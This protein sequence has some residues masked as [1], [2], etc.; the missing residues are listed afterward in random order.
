MDTLDRWISKADAYVAGYLRTLNVT[1]SKHNV[2]SALCVAELE[3]RCGD[4][5]W[6]NWGG[7]TA[8]QLAPDERAR[9]S[10]AN[11]SPSNPDDLLAA[12]N[13]LGPQPHKVLGQDSDPRAGWYWIWFYLPSTPADGAAYFVKVLVVQRPACKT[14]LEDDNG[15]LD[16]LARA[17][18]NSHYYSGHYDPHN[19]SV[20]YNGKQMPGDEANIESYRDSLLRIQQGLI[21]TLTN[22]TPSA[23][24]YDLST[25]IGLQEALTYLAGKLGKT[26]LDPK[27]IDGDIGPDTVAAIKALQTY[28]GLDVDGDAGDETKTAIL[29][30]IAGVAG[31]TEPAPPST[32]SS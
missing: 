20:N 11:L 9:L 25:T 14:I 2:T 18:Y 17:M 30:L 22:W 21:A 3:T 7:T 13:L 24:A 16:Q 6:G 19:P 12:Q 5:C 28:A 31:T 4:A 29:K 15:T 8:E 27:G 26:P 1:P 32:S 23:A 10:A